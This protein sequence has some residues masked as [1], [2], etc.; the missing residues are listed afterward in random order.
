MKNKT[1]LFRVERTP[2]S[3]KDVNPSIRNKTDADIK[4]LFYAFGVCR[5]CADHAVAMLR[6]PVVRP[7]KPVR[8]PE[9]Y[10]AGE[11]IGFAVCS[12]ACANGIMTAMTM[13]QH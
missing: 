12:E 11:P 2:E 8:T 6:A 10:Y 1:Q 13:Q 3:E 4:S 5:R 7:S 9:G